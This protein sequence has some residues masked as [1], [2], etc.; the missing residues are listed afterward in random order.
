MK[1]ED[2]GDW[3]LVVTNSIFK[4]WW[5]DEVAEFKNGHCEDYNINYADEIGMIPF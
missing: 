5:K 4:K 2:D 3:Y 1:L